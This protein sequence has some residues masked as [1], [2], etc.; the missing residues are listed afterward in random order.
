M[1]YDCRDAESA[2]PP[3]KQ[4]ICSVNCFGGGDIYGFRSAKSSVHDSEQVGEALMLEGA[5]QVHVEMWLD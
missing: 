4:S 2:P 5:Y 3:L 1:G